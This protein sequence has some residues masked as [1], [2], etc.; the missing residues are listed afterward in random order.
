MPNPPGMLTCLV[1]SLPNYG[2]LEDTYGVL[3]T[4]S[5]LPYTLPD[6]TNTVQYTSQ[7]CFIGQDSFTFQADD[8]GQAPDGGLSNIATVTIDVQTTPPLNPPAADF[9]YDCTVDYIDFAIF[10]A[11]WLSTAGQPNFNPACDIAEPNDSTIDLADLVVF[12]R[13]WLTSIE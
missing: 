13:Q 7:P 8:S 3:I 11:A 6:N 4:Q 10:S 12:C 9:Q 2:T 5:A 1:T